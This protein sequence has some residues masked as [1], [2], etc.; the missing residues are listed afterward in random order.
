MKTETKHTPGPWENGYGY[1]VTGPTTPRVGGPCCDHDIPYV[2]VRVGTE[3]LA[4][5]PGVAKEIAEANARLIAA[6]PEL[7]EACRTALRHI[8]GLIADK[9]L[10]GDAVTQTL[11]LAIRK[12]EG[13]K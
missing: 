3:V 10:T 2:V 9:G 12:A 13:G 8:R 6:A 5:V 4:I 7:L 11:D 1:G